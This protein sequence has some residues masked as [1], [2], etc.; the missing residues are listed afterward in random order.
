MKLSTIEYIG[1]KPRKKKKR[2][3]LLA[4]LLLALLIGAGVFSVMNLGIG[5]SLAKDVA[6]SKKLTIEQLE[7]TVLSDDTF[8]NNLAKAGLYRTKKDVSYDPAYYNIE[9]PM[10]DLPSNKGICTDVIIRA[11]R[12]VGVD[13]Q[14]LIHEDM[15]KSF[16]SYPNTWGLEKR[17]SNI[18]H[19][20]VPNIQHFLTRNGKSL[21][22][23]ENSGDYNYGDIVVWKLS[24]GEPHI[25]IV[26]PSPLENDS[27][28][29]IVHNVGNGP[30]WENR[31]FDY[32][33][34]GHFRFKAH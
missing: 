15:G 2:K 32:K 26:V 24:H 17:D 8:A 33:I 11:Y 4:V 16:D 22:I 29:W 18:D 34:T 27:M 21:I 6:P 12:E 9:Y 3:G 19:R 31:L 30:K 1:A 7:S 14:E 5:E 25:G 10:G 13:L 28:P 20:R 23:S